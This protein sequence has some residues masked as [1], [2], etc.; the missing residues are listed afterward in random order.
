MDP[1]PPFHTPTLSTAST[2][3]LPADFTPQVSNGATNAYLLSYR[4]LADGTIHSRMDEI[5]EKT[6]LSQSKIG[7]QLVSGPVPGSNAGSLRRQVTMIPAEFNK[8]HFIVP[9]TN[10]SG[11]N[12]TIESFCS[13]ERQVAIEVCTNGAPAIRYFNG[14][15]TKINY[16]R[17]DAENNPGTNS[18]A[19]IWQDIS[20]DEK[21]SDGI[22]REGEDTVKGET[23]PVKQEEE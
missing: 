16:C 14:K 9:D 11:E 21:T 19:P 20:K 1:T 18:Q 7:S 13:Q 15:Q 23:V 4:T 22:K 10:A 12:V 5:Y 17:S 2:A 6:C 8:H 3:A